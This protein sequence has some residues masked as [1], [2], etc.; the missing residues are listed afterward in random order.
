MTML[1]VFEYGSVEEAVL[2]ATGAKTILDANP[3][4]DALMAVS[5]FDDDSRELDQIPEACEMMRAFG[6]T[7]GTKYLCRFDP[8]GIA[9]VLIAMNSGACRVGYQL[10]IS[11]DAIKKLAK[12]EKEWRLS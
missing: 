11:P 6:D 4:A 12:A 8:A 2:V 9:L 10:V 7:L 5:G 1:A 3:T